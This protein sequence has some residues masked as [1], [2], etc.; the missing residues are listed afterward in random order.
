[1]SVIFNRQQVETFLPHRQPFL[2]IDQVLNIEYPSQ[3]EVQSQGRT[4]TVKELLHGVVTCEYTPPED[5]AIFQGH[6]PGNPI[7]PGVLQVESM[8]Q[9]SAFLMTEYKGRQ[10]GHFEIKPTLLG[11]DQSRFKKPIFPGMHLMIRSQLK[12]FR[13]FYM[14]YHAEIFYEDELCSSTDLL[15]SIEFLN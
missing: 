15:A 8:A 3:Q 9:A 7:F 1:M 2:F 13:G 10:L 12:K 6:F 5:H 14:N 11:V 4:P